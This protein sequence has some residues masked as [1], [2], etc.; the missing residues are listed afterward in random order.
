MFW[1]ASGRATLSGQKLPKHANVQNVLGGARS[2]TLLQDR[3][4]SPPPP[5]AGGTEGQM[6]L[7]GEGGMTREFRFR[8]GQCDR[9]RHPHLLQ[10]K[11]R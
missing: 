7:S 4:D 8:G 9:E 10:D 6:S 2:T 5:T 11:G 1:T 3:T